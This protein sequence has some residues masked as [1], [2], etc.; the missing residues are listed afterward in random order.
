M[1]KKSV[2]RWALGLWMLIVIWAAFFYAPAARGF[3]GESARIVFFHVPQAWVAVLAFCVNL[4]ASLRYLRGRD[5]IDD[6]RAATAARLG[7]IFSVLATVTGSLFARVMWGSFWNWDPREVSIAILLLVYA[8]Y[9]ALR[10]AIPDD[11]RRASL[12]ASYAVLAFVTMPFLIF[13]VPRIYWSLHPDTII[14]T[15]GSLDMESRMFQTLMGSLVGFT[16]LFFWLYSL[17]V[18]LAR[19]RIARQ[20]REGE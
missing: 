6:A 11:E 4:I 9:F 1:T 14:N 19:V 5:L 18:R 3:K 8:A 20:T 13:V 16:G 2:W 7:L 17:D 12:S 10:E 15:R